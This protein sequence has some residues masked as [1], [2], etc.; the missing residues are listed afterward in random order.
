MGKHATLLATSVLLIAGCASATTGTGG[1]G[2]TSTVASRST[3]GG[4]GAQ[5]AER[6]LEAEERAHGDPVE[7]YSGLGASRIAFIAHHTVTEGAPPAHPVN[8]TEEDEIVAVDASGRV[9][10]YVR[11]FHF[12][13]AR[14]TGERLTLVSGSDLPGSPAVVRQTS[15][16]IDWRSPILARLIDM[17][18]AQAVTQPESISVT[19]Q[20]VSRPSC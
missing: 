19:M 17:E 15:T 8:G 7:P 4:G 20:A 11:T 10:K 12:D 9:T 5:A 16:C 18:Y 2:A 6:A 3:Q 1:G 14:S 13:P